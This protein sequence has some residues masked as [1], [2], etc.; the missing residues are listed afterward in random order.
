MT[1]GPALRSG[2]RPWSHLSAFPVD[3]YQRMHL[4]K[5][6]SIV[7]YTINKNNTAEATRDDGDRFSLSAT[8]LGFDDT[9]EWLK[10]LNHDP[11]GLPVRTR[12]GNIWRGVYPTSLDLKRQIEFI[13]VVVAGDPGM[14]AGF[15]ATTSSRRT[16]GGRM[17]L[18]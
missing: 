16:M 5:A 2:N 14:L 8:T 12:Y 17:A 11:Y 18:H 7:V 9:P 6:R 10:F 1:G 15:P 3:T 4:S 13:Y